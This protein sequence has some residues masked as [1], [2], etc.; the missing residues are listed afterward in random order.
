V[1]RDRYPVPAGEKVGLVNHEHI[2]DYLQSLSLNWVGA[3][4]I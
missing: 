4:A 3:P 1:E 2:E